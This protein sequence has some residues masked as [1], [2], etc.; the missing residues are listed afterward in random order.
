MK[1]VRDLP[2]F[3]VLTIMVLLLTGCGKK[4]PPGM[5][6]P[7]PCEIIVM[8]EDKPLEDAVVRLQPTDNSSWTAA[9]RTDSSGKAIVYTMDQYK[10]AIPGKYK[11]SVSKTVMEAADGFYLVDRQYGSAS[12]TPLEIDVAKGTAAYTVDVGKAVRIKAETKR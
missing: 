5:P 8:Q 12:T 3:L 6:S 4:L 10:G 1:T 11:V 7:V 9:G 2:M